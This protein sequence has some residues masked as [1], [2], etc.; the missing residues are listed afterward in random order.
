MKNPQ[1]KI[2]KI[3]KYTCL[4]LVATF[5]LFSVRFSILA[6]TSVIDNEIK[7]LNLSI[8][9]QRQKIDEIKEK[10]A[11]YQALI[12][13]TIKDKLSLSSQLSILDNKLAKAELD[14][15]SANLEIDK[16]S[17]EIKKVER[18]KE[19]LDI[20]INEKKEHIASLLRL[21]Y[22]QDQ[23]STIEMLLLN[24]SLSD[25]LND[26]KYLADTNLEIGNSVDDLKDD[27]LK[28]DR[29]EIILKEKN[30]DLI[31][32]KTELEEKKLNLSYEQENKEYILD[33]TKL[34][35]QAYQNLLQ[36]MKK[37]QAQ[38]EAEIVQAEQLIRQKM[39]EKDRG[40]LD[41][42]DTSILSW[43]VP[44]N[45]ITAKFH[46]PDYPYTSVL[47]SHSAVDIRAAQG[48]TITAAADGYVAKVKFNG[49]KDYAYIMIIHGNNISTVYG[50]VS[51]VY[52]TE[53]QYVSRGEAIG[54]TGGM[55]GTIGAG[56]F[57]T[58]PHIHFEVRLNGLP[59]NPENYLN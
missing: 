50:H 41:S 11:K 23:S 29:N 58:G 37:Q 34:S 26:A 28:L 12:E 8:T 24:E 22:K 16:T 9:N 57:T 32:L 5:V 33:K 42:F 13:E 2:K 21:A 48:T 59:V 15:D 14:I 39:T 43:P 46:D 45:V 4:S 36:E 47:G 30:D 35:E 3:L 20:K 10:Q 31:T 52:V 19:S 54:R 38:A 17:L 25:F 53:D 18:E 55:P 6:N 7:D 51:A 49:T 56:P 44:K 1:N 27:K 40:F